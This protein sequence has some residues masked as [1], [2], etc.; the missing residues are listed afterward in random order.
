MAKAADPESV[1]VTYDLFDLP[2]AQHKAGLAGLQ[3]QIRH[4][5]GKSPKPP[6]IPAIVAETPTSLSVTFTRDSAQALMDDV[7]AAERAEV[8]VKKKWPSAKEIRPSEV[9]VEEVNEKPANVRYFFHEVVQPTGGLL[10]QHVRHE[11]WLKLWRDMLWAIPRGNPQSREPFEQR[12]DG[13]PCK[14]GGL[15]WAGLVKADKARA[16]GGFATGPVAGSLWLGAQASNAE[17]VPFEGRVEQTLLLHFWPLTALVYVPQMVQPDGSSEFV[18][19][20]L[21]V[22]E[23]SDLEQFPH[24][25]NGLLADLGEELRGYRPAGA[26]IDLPAEGALSFLDHLAW[27]AADKTAAAEV[28]LSVG[29]VEFL[30]MAKFGNNIK[31]MANGRVVPRPNL[32]DDYRAI[33]GDPGQKPAFANP[34]FRRGLVLALLNNEPWFRPFGKMFGEWDARFFVP[35]DDPPKLMWF[36]SDARKKLQE[37]I[38][39]M[40]T[41]PQP[42]DPPP[43][44]D[45]LLM[46]LVHRLARTYLAE[47]AKQKSGIDPDK[48]K[49]GDKIAWDR[50]PKEY[51]DARRAAGES[52]FLEFRSRR[53]QGFIDHFAQT[54][55]ATKQYVSEDH[56]TEIG[57]ALMHRTE[58]VK[59]LTLMALSANS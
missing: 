3:M 4:M 25:Y 13:K 26:V 22:P 20:A 54:F 18:G 38:Q 33:V 34:L 55:F 6:A 42:G 29:S 46:M 10:R 36:W 12:A 48:F 56:Y 16:A 23:V 11:P 9:V 31:V 41:N 28:R 57:R 52:L 51:T 27:L 58:D 43:S 24:D 5:E 37:V 47:R 7:Y 35:S 44:A 59:T 1:T 2:T 19:Y 30:H 14:E 40:P 32:L 21:A 53:D 49:D 15:A 45:D 50:L 39:A 17:L 8:R